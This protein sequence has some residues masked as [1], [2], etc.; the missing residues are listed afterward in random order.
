[1]AAS[2]RAEIQDLDRADRKLQS[3]FARTSNLFPLMDQIGALVTEQSRMRFET[4]RAPS[5][6]AWEQSGRAR[7]QG[8]QTLVDTGRLR[9]SLQHLAGATSAQIGTNVLY[10]AAHQFGRTE[11]ETVE[12]HSRRIEQAFGR[13]LKFPVYQNVRTHKRNP[14]IV[15]RPF[16]GLNGDDR[17]EINDVVGAYI[18][19]AQR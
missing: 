4:Q 9:D 14:N 16:L 1:M 11:V 18:E 8:G 15:A 12:A 6:E 17:E 2:I 19:A 5:G 7:E 13:P 3:L 10:A